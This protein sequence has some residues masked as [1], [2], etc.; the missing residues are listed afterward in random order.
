MD[1][2][3][4]QIGYEFNFSKYFYINKPIR[5]FREISAEIKL[6]EKEIKELTI[7]LN[8]D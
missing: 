2:S 4:D 3:K 7:Q 8:D 6:L 5:N 1:R